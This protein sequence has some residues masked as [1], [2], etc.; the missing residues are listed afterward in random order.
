MASHSHIDNRDEGRRILYLIEKMGYAKRL[1][2]LVVVVLIAV[3]AA[4]CGAGGGKTFD[5][6]RAYG[7][8]IEQVSF[9][10]RPPGSEALRRTGEYISEHLEKVGWSVWMQEFTYQGVTLRNIFAAK[11]PDPPIE[12]AILLGA[13]Y[14][15]RPRADRET[16]ASRRDEAILGA[17]DGASGVAVLLE[18]ARVFEEERCGTEVILAFFDAEDSG[19]INGWPFSVGAEAAAEELASRLSQ[20]IVVDMVGDADQQFYYERGSDP[21]IQQELWSIAN[22]LGYSKWFIP[23]PRHGVIDDHVPFMRRGVHSVD[24]I[25][26]D[27]AYWHTLQDTADKVTEDS[28]E[29]VGRVLLEYL[30]SQ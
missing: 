4:G 19:N 17:N 3:V 22:D 21:G 27:Y 6:A 7:H 26:F 14:D 18:L 15:T 1:I 11:S 23:E 30:Y 12:A 5:G 16:D 9:G 28:L 24:I 20:V 10:P 13:H 25:D 8:V 29:R 2:L